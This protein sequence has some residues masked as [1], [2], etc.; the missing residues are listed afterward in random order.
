MKKIT[1]QLFIN[2]ILGLCVLSFAATIQAQT[3]SF[4]FQGRLSDNNLAANGTYEMQFALFDSV[5]G[6]NQIGSTVSNANVSV[7]GGIFTAAL[8]FGVN[9][10]TGANRF[11]QI[12]VRTAGNQNPPTILIP[13]QPVTSAPY[14]IKSLNS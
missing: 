10:F 3:T 5:S 2:L 7:A 6:G 11:L 12:S 8:D 14:S 4:T 9:S 13:R 1:R